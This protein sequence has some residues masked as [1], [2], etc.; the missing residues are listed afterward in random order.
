M[1]NIKRHKEKER[2]TERKRQRGREARTKHSQSV[3][4]M[5]VGTHH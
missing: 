4:L 1:R 5:A 3:P 2:D